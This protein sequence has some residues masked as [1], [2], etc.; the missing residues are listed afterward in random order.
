MVRTQIQLS[1][2]QVE[3]VKRVAARRGVSMA[4]VIRDLIEHKLDDIDDYAR[5]E[6]RALAAIGAFTGVPGNAGRDHD[7]W[8]AEAYE[9]WR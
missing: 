6:A 8:L 3:R 7:E 9:D 4:T 1:E 5:R 2:E